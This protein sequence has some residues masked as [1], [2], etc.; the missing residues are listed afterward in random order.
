LCVMM[1]GCAEDEEKET[2]PT[3][4]LIATDPPD[5][6]EIAIGKFLTLT[7]DYYPGTVIVNGRYAKVKRPTVGKGWIATWQVIGLSPGPVSL[8]IQWEMGHATLPLTLFSPVPTIK[9]LEMQDEVIDT[10]PS[11]D[12]CFLA[13]EEKYSVTFEGPVYRTECQVICPPFLGGINPSSPNGNGIKIRFTGPLQKGQG[14]IQLYLLTEQERVPIWFGL[15]EDDFVWIIPDK[16][17][18]LG[19]GQIYLIDI[20]GVKDISGHHSINGKITFST[21]PPS[22]IDRL[23]IGDMTITTR[24]A[25]VRDGCYLVCSESRER[26]QEGLTQKFFH[27]EV[28]CFQD[29]HVVMLAPEPIDVIT[30]YFKE[31]IQEKGHIALQVTTQVGWQDLNWSAEW[32]T[33]FVSL[34]KSEPLLHGKYHQ[35]EIKDVKDVNG[36]IL[37][38]AIGFWTK[39]AE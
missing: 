15:I 38:G 1:M 10:R 39:K 6:S 24:N 27:C 9:A 4:H 2:L 23:Q 7:F 30:I 26:I 33:D 14:T 11:A 3:A 35:I 29:F 37:E 32:G 22:V 12:Q 16:A 20:Q 31:S 8:D 19:N 18:E 28:W 34:V 36:N 17:H 21:I 5:G 13:C 25:G